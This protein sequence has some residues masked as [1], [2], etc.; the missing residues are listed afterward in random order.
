V[1]GCDFSFQKYMLGNVST[2]S[3]NMRS[4]LL[5]NVK[6]IAK[7]I[8]GL[9]VTEAGIR[10]DC[11]VFLW[12]PRWAFPA[13]RNRGKEGRSKGAKEERRKGGTENRR[14]GGREEG[15]KGGKEQNISL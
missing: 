5:P 14:R 10:V 3:P 13:S 15:R 1:Y 2:H 8:L 6:G 11:Q 7:Y 12:L 9:E 4:I